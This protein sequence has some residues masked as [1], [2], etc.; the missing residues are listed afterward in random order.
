MRLAP[1]AKVLLKERVLLSLLRC[2]AGDFRVWN[3]VV[4]LRPIQAEGYARGIS[5]LKDYIR[6]KR[7]LRPACHVRC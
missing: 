7:A 4:I 2:Q 1:R 5:I 3:A 6:P